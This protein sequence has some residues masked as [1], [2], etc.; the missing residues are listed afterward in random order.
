MATDVTIRVSWSDGS[1][2]SHRI[3]G[4]P[5]DD[6]EVVSEV[7]EHKLADYLELDADWPTDSAGLPLAW[8]A[9]QVIA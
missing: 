1:L 4:L 3:C 6:P 2:T 5:Y 9:V 7:L 8:V